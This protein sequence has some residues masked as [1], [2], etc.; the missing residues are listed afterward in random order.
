MG[1]GA[2][3]LHRDAGATITVTQNIYDDPDFFAGYSRLPRS[4]AGL[5][6]AP[7]W[8][9]LR[10]LLPNLAGRSVLDLG[11]GFGWFCRW[12]RDAGAAHVTGLDVS[13]NMLARARAETADPGIVYRQAD[14]EQVVLPAAA[15]DLVFSSLTFH[16]LEHLD[17]LLASAAA[18]LRPGGALVCSVE[19]PIYTA[20]THPGW[21]VQDERR[22][23]PVDGYL[24][25]GP[26]RTDWLAPGVIKQHRTLG[27]YV[28]LL[29]DAGFVLTALQDW[30][31]TPEQIAAQ[32]AL[33]MELE[34]PMFLLLGGRSGLDCVASN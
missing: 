32:P 1:A 14:L 22:T 4:V 2:A 28:S 31:P 29:L 18:A 20:P 34:R 5:D 12:A 24:R 30:C 13:E 16:Y 3:A 7:E 21:V 11:C 15:Y 27:R 23:W 19:H 6:G 25:E 9:A 33:A 26:R 10:A 8:P 17:R